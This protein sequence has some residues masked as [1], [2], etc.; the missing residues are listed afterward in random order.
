MRRHRLKRRYGRAGS[1]MVKWNVFEG[2]KHVDSV[3]YDPSM[4]ADE[5]RRSLVNHDGYDPGIVVKR[6]KAR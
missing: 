5:V 3:F 6:E 4:G 2:R 1:R